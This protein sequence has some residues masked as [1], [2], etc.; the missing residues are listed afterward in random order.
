MISISQALGVP[1]PAFWLTWKHILFHFFLLCTHLCVP[2][3]LKVKMLLSSQLSALIV[4]IVFFF[5]LT[6]CC[7][8]LKKYIILAITVICNNVKKKWYRTLHEVEHETQAFGSFWSCIPVCDSSIN[9]GWTGHVMTQMFRRLVLS[10]CV[11]WR[12]LVVG[13]HPRFNTANGLRGISFLFLILPNL[14]RCSGFAPRWSS[15]DPVL[16]TPLALL[17]EPGKP[18]PTTTF[19]DYEAIDT[20]LLH[21][22]DSKTSIVTWLKRNLD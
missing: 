5:F 3:Q 16:L 6:N 8:A 14:T 20:Y 21:L 10:N 13:H 12:C 15:L 22:F 9:T 11:L 18:P 2:P 19:P 17:A 7:W 4:Q 1:N